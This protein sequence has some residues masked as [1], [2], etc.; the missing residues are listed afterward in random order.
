MA[1]SEG[2][3]DSGMR[4]ALTGDAVRQRLPDWYRQQTCFP[5]AS[6]SHHYKA[7]SALTH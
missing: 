4:R 5:N 6:M 1:V 2:H 7:P 3:W